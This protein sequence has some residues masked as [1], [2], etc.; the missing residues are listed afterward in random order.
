MPLCITPPGRPPPESFDA[1]SIVADPL[2]M[3]AA[4]G[5]F[6]LQADS[7]AISKLGWQPIPPIVAPTARC[8]EE[9]PASPACLAVILG[10]A[11]S[12][13][14]ARLAALVT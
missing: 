2:F 8:G 1:H 4:A 7:P 6:R 12:T 9:A 10:G 14:H 3:D 11:D 5:D 13:G